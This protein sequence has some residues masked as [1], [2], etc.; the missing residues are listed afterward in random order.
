MKQVLLATFILSSLCSVA[1]E[2]RMVIQG[3]IVD[4][5]GDPVSDVYIINLVSHE[6]DITLQ[7]GVFTIKISPTDSLILSHISYF[8]KVVS[9]TS[10]LL[11]PVITLEGESLNI[12]EITVTPDQMTDEERVRENLQQE[13]WDIK[14]RV[15]DG[16]TDEDRV[17]QTIT[18]NN[19][20]FR[21]EASS[22]TFL[23]FSFQSVIFLANGRK[24]GR[25]E[26]ITFNTY[27]RAEAL[28]QTHIKKPG[29]RPGLI[30]AELS[31]LNFTIST[32][33]VFLQKKNRPHFMRTVPA[34]FK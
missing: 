20:V 3:K 23:R 13:K 1:Q 21:S 18:A 6:K 15:G 4:T 32:I 27:L 7:N 30:K 16:F 5:K 10:L 22:V 28:Y 33:S 17:N 26:R 14:P 29:L 2:K 9:A 34:I 11:N 12:E 24:R 19:G 31:F 25:R 8:R